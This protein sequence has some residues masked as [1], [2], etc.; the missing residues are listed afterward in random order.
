MH[1]AKLNNGEWLFV[2]PQAFLHKQDRPRPVNAGPDR[3]LYDERDKQAHHQKEWQQGK[4]D[5]NVQ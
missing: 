2:Q 1:G 5:Y 3:N 4:R